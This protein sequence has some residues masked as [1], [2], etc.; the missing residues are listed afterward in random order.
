[1]PLIQYFQLKYENW[2]LQGDIHV[3]P[4][5]KRVLF[6]H[7]AGASSRSRF[8]EL[9][10]E[11]HERGVGSTAFDCVGHGATGGAMA[12]SSLHSRTSQAAAVAAATGMGKQALA[13][14]GFSMGAYNAIRLTQQMRVDALILVVPGI[15]DPRAYALPFGPRFSAAIRRER[16][17]IDSDAWGILAEF[18]GDLLVIAAADDAVIPAEIPQRLVASALVARSRR[19]HVVAGAT[20]NHLFALLRERPEELDATMALIMGCVEVA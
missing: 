20:H 5:D 15:Y 18:T 13:V 1:M 10:R 4:L 6:I 12:Q 8:A 9:R 2:T 14:F 11:L 19:L 3:A 16:S 17:W 7:G